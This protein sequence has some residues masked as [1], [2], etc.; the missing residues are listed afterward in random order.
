[1]MRRI[2]VVLAVSLVV[3][4]S[5]AAKGGGPS[6]GVVQGGI[7]GPGGAV[8]YVVHA[9]AARTVVSA[10]P[11]RGGRRPRVPPLGGAVGIPRVAFDGQ[12]GGVSADG[13]TLV[14]ASFADP[15]KLA[16]LST[17]TLATQRLVSLDGLYSYDAISPNG[18]TIYLVEYGETNYRVRSYDV[19]SGQ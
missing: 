16:V 2:V 15:T 11:R 7:V 14:L 9:S 12:T 8:R 3:A 6:P 19:A 4:A 18:R 5:A 13:R 17:G 10:G 1:G